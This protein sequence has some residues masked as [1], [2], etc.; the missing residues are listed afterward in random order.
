MKIPRVNLSIGSRILVVSGLVAVLALIVALIS[1]TYVRQVGQD[2]SRVAEHDRLLQTSALELRLTVEQENEAILGYLLAGDPAFQDTL[3]QA[4]ASYSATARELIQ[5]NLSDADAQ[6]VSEVNTLHAEFS[7]VAQEQS[8]LRDRGFPQAAVFLWQTEGDKL[9]LAMDN[10]LD[11]LAAMQETDILKHTGQAGRRET[12]ALWVAFSLV[13]LTWI[14]GI[15]ASLWITRGIT[16]PIK[17]LVATAD[18]IGRGNLQVRLPDLGQDELGQLGQATNRMASDLEEARVTADQ[19]LRQEQRRTDQLRMINEAGRQI[20]SVLSLDDLLPHIASRLREIFGYYSVNVFL[21]D[22][23]TE[24]LVLEAGAGGYPERAPIGTELRQNVDGIVGWVAQTGTSF[25]A[26]DV[27]REPRFIPTEELEDTRSEI[28]VPIKASGQILGVLDFRS[29]EVN[30][31]DEIDVLTAELL[32]DQVGVA[33]KNAEYYEQAQDMATMRER[34][35]LARDLH[36]SVTQT[37]FSAALIAEVLPTLWDR[38]AGEGKVRLEELRLLT[39]GALA[40][41]RMLLMELRPTTLTE[42]DL[43]EILGH[44]ARAFSGRA[45]VPVQLTADGNCRLP[46]ATQVAMYRIAQEALNNVAKHAHAS[47]VAMILR[48]QSGTV[49]ISVTDNGR[50]FDPQNLSARHLGIKIMKER[51][52]AAEIRLT[53]ESAIDQGTRV[54]ASWGNPEPT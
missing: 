31:L 18:E 39:R 26:R 54:H 42:T 34:Q 46:P 53:I 32:A 2:L 38:N 47:Q 9:K 41:M 4:T 40:E 48:H 22:P 44:L 27:S 36:D 3:A 51:A 43:G 50:G 52:E 33:I 17:Q 1:I 12:E 11:D 20:S 28:A 7:K 15:G 35:R 19:L 30:G 23:D 29:T 14:V 13:G 21:I 5:L 6:T 49:E 45:R 24:R 8:T 25:L 37:L 16:R 10:K